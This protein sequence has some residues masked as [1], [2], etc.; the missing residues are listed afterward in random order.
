MKHILALWIVLGAGLGAA[1]AGEGLPDEE[2][3]RDIAGELRCPTCTGLSV[4]DSDASFSVQIKDEVRRQLKD[5]AD[6]EAIL[7]FLM[8]W[9]NA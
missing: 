6:K 9:E 4:L 5:G 7:K 8:T 1:W 2:V 3:F